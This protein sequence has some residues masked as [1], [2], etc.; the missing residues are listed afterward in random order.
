MKVRIPNLGIALLV[1][2]AVTGSSSSS[3]NK[4]SILNLAI[5]SSD[6]SFRF[7][8]NKVSKAHSVAFSPSE[9]FN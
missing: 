3:S 7:V 5:T 8:T 2:T 4:G 9:N 6:Q 1:R